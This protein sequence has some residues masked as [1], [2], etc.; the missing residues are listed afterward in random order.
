MCSRR[1][2]TDVATAT[3]A[4][5]LALLASLL[6]FVLGMLTLYHFKGLLA[7]QSGA[8]PHPDERAYR[9]HDAGVAHRHRRFPHRAA[10]QQATGAPAAWSGSPGAGNCT[11]RISVEGRDEVAQL[12]RAF[13]DAAG[14]IRELLGAHKA[15]FANASHELRTPLTRIR[16]AVELMKDRVDPRHKEGLEQDIAEWIG[17]WIA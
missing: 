7:C 10:D 1:C 6:L 15:L 5:Y 8:D 12:A 11:A 14:R 3:C 17:S 9:H 2:R 16:L 4:S 13:N